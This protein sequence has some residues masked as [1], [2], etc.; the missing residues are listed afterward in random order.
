MA[1]HAKLAQMHFFP[2]FLSNNIQDWLG[3]NM[4]KALFVLS[5]HIH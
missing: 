3:E 4:E 5:T 1:D 2:V